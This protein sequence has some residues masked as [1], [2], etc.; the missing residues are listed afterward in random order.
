M[1]LVRAVDY[2]CAFHFNRF[3]SPNEDVQL[4]TV[5]SQQMTAKPAT[6]ICVLSNWKETRLSSGNLD[7]LAQ[8][9]RARRILAGKVARENPG[10]TAG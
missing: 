6:E 9:T 1:A 4:V 5:S 10:K 8:A 2:R 3:V 7:L